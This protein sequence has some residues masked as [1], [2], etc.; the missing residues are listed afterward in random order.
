MI[1]VTERTRR[2]VN[3]RVNFRANST[4]LSMDLILMSH[5]MFRITKYLAAQ[6]REGRQGREVM[7]SLLKTKMS[8]WT[9]LIGEHSQIFHPPNHSK[10]GHLDPGRTKLK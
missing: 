8:H 1:Q 2:V 6:W 7:H 10:R 9:C 3:E 4:K 5:S